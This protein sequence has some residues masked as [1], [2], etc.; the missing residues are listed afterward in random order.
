MAIY[1]N[2][3]MAFWTDAKIADYTPEQKLLFLYLLT[4]PHTNL[5]GCYEIAIK[6]IAFETGYT[7]AKVETL[8]DELQQKQVVYYNRDTNEMLVTNWGRYN[9]TTSDKFIKAIQAEFERVKHQ[10]FRE[11]LEKMAEGIDRVCIPYKYPITSDVSVI[12]SDTVSDTVSNTNKE[13][14]KTRHKYGLYSN[15]L[16]SDEDVEALQ[17]E[18]PADWEKRIDALSTYMETK[19]AKY[20]NHLAVIRNWARR[21][22]NAEAGRHHT[23]FQ[24]RQFG[25]NL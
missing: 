8:I 21:E 19:G 13:T 16:L 15:V 24:G 4:N 17:A 6:Q 7:P 22:S 5:C 20:K 3:H 18:F 12:V 1:R 10:P 9:W 25:T 11:Y 23:T 14:K 2:V